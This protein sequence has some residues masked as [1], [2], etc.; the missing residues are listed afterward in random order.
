MVSYGQYQ[1][2]KYKFLGR[3]SL[4][5]QKIVILGDIILRFQTSIVL[6]GHYKSGQEPVFVCGKVVYWLVRKGN[7]KDVYFKN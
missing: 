1:E 6:S 2:K 3:K 5:R 4:K 7:V